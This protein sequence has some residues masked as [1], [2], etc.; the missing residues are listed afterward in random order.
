MTVAIQEHTFCLL[1]ILG[2]VPVALDTRVLQEMV[3]NAP[4]ASSR[5]AVR[6]RSYGILPWVHCIPCHPLMLAPTRTTQRHSFHHTLHIQLTGELVPKQRTRRSS[7][8]SAVTL[9]W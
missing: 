1:T 7:L 3:K 2:V 5:T 4:G 6:P 8:V 9:T